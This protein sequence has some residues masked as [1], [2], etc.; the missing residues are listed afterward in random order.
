M[1]TKIVDSVKN[2][3]LAEIKDY[4]SLYI[5]RYA[6][7]DTL[8]HIAVATKSL[9]VVQLILEK[10]PITLH[11]TNSYKLT[12]MDLA[13]SFV[14]KEIYDYLATVPK[15]TLNSKPDYNYNLNDICSFLEVKNKFIQK[16]LH[17]ELEKKSLNVGLF[18]LIMFLKLVYPNIDENLLRPLFSKYS[19]YS[20]F[21]LEYPLS[22]NI[23][24]LM[25]QI[26]PKR[27]IRMIT[28][29][30]YPQNILF[31]LFANINHNEVDLSDV[32]ISHIKCLTDIKS[33]IDVHVAYKI[34]KNFKLKGR[35]LKKIFLKEQIDNYDI[36]IP[37]SNHE[38]IKIA[39]HFKNCVGNGMYASRIRQDGTLNIS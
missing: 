2:K 4:S 18:N 29:T 6:N 33:I 26:P 10:F 31:P 37:L 21:Y 3:N 23:I 9:P 12:P 20:W 22:D 16:M 35:F 13:R 34:Q 11:C 36:V 7:E 39:H 30:H 8:L 14:D 17:K 38:L 5:E 25:K 32:D 28:Q 27:F 24:F 1:N 19:N 15:I